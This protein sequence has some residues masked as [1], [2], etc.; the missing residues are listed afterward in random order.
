MTG[1]LCALSSA[2]LTCEYRF[3][4]KAWAWYFAS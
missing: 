1:V 3:S 4:I 2:Q